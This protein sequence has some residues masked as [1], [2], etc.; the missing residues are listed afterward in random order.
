[1]E[2]QH[3]IG[4]LVVE[5]QLPSRDDAFSIQQALS[6]RCNV[7]LTPMLSQLLDSWADP[8][9]LLQIDKLEV[10]LGNC[11]MKALQEELPGMVIA[12]LQK[13]FQDATAVPSPELNIQQMQRRPLT[14]GYFESWL[15]FMQHGVLPSTAVR[16]E[17]EEWEAGIL[18]AL[19]TET[20]ALKQCQDL[21]SA[22]PYTVR[23]LVMQFSRSFV[24]NWVLAF[25]AGAYRQQLV[26]IDEW[27]AFVF[28]PRFVTVMKAQIAQQSLPSLPLPAHS[29]YATQVMEWLIG[30]IVIAGKAIS[31]PALLE[32]LVR[33]LG[34]V[35]Q[36]PARL[37][38]LERVTAAGVSMPVA[39]H[40]AI[41]AVAG[42]YSAEMT[43][44]R[45]TFSTTPAI[46]SIA[47]D[48]RTKDQQEAT[49]RLRREQQLAAAL[50]R[51]QE[52]DT[53]AKQSSSSGAPSSEAADHNKRKDQKDQS[54]SGESPTAE[55]RSMADKGTVSNE[56]KHSSDT[57][58]GEEPAPAGLPEEGTVYY[59]NNAGLILLH[60]Y[61]SYCFDALELR[62]GQQFKDETAKHK[63]VQLIGYMAYGEE[64]IPEW[65]LVLPKILCGISPT[66][67][68]R[69]FMPLS[70]AEK[71]EANQLLGAVI[72][73]WNALGNTSP[74]GLRGNFLLREGK[75]EW[76]E[77]EWQ[78]FVTQQA[79]D[80]LL[81]RLPWGFSVV[82]LSWMPWLIKTVW[83]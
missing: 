50:R 48:G 64:E 66:E 7:E 1:M 42:R 62:E 71:D 53:A 79:Y 45:T 57:E 74:D 29:H 23:R 65:D 10:D 78:L 38:T 17:Q 51:K 63:A 68:V 3:A 15:Y 19:A 6:M 24:Y 26:L 13:H 32:Q 12:Y 75:L 73:H 33:L 60:P 41:G 81:N 5:V 83:V 31:H 72:T 59:I 35:S 44:L 11:N 76:K 67:P 43:E 58:T 77:E 49:E 20:S 30:D 8:D 61:L 2:Q 56:Q 18:T 52:Q 80:M 21:L 39:V 54:T 82:G 22:H 4:K 34:S 37:F 25:S 27:D 36:L 55:E 46:K 16:W 40:E 14:Q 9:T 70:E 69:R 47:P 28:S